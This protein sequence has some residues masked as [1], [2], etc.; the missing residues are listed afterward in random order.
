MWC[1]CCAANRIANAG[2]AAADKQGPLPRLETERWRCAMA[3]SAGGMCAQPYS[4]SHRGRHSARRF[5][6]TTA[7]GPVV[8][9]QLAAWVCMALWWVTPG[10]NL[11]AGHTQQP[12][13]PN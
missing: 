3:R 1:C 8:T 2:A 10:Q 11:L 6:V 4:S 9:W 7:S 13:K 5:A 12:S